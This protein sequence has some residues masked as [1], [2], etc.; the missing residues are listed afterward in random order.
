M[1]DFFV[2]PSTLTTGKFGAI[3]PKDLKFSANKDLNRLKKYAKYQ[4][5]RSI[6]KVGF[7]F[8]K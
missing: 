7:A 1:V 4:E 3:R 5:G 2:R 8:S 6:L